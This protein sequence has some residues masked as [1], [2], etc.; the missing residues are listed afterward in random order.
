MVD[1]NLRQVSYLLAVLEEGHFGRAADRLYISAPALTQQV[2]KLEDRLGAELIDRSRHP[3]RATETGRRFVAEAR[4]A[5]AAAER[6]IAA[7]RRTTGRLRIGFMTAA[8]DPHARTLLHR[9]RERNP[10]L[11]VELVELSWS[12]TTSAVRAGLVDATLMRPPVADRTHLR[13]DELC[14][15]GRVAALPATHRLAGR[16]SISVSDLDGDIHVTDDA[17]EPGWVKWWA[18][19]P[20]PS[21]R[22]VVYGPSAHTMAEVL[23]VVALGEAISIT[24]EQVPLS[25]RHPHVVFVPIDDVEPAHLCLCTRSADSTPAVESARA[26]VGEL[27]AEIAG[28]GNGVAVSR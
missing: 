23:E 2:K 11:L 1:L 13:F 8:I 19:D 6:A 16:A 28:T 4:E 26:V 22:E 20:R 24:D 14:T 21:G 3:L 17:A 7:V 25:H 9:L 27:R 18:C 12:E 5:V 10:E 15:E